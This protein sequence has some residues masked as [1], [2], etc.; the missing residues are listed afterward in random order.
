MA[1]LKVA[2]YS[3]EIPSTTFI[4]QLVK[5][6]GK[7]DMEVLLFG[8]LKKKVSYSGNIRIISYPR[9]GISKR[10]KW[11]IFLIR[12][13]LHSPNKFSYAVR[14]IREKNISWSMKITPILLYQPDVFHL[15]WAKAV[16][17]WLFLKE[18]FGVKLVISLR[19]A[20]INYSPVGSPEVADIYKRSFPQYDI[21]HAVSHDIGR[22]ARWY[23]MPQDRVRVIR[24]GLSIP[25]VET[26]ML[27][28]KGTGNPIKLISIGRPHWIKG[29]GYALEALAEFAKQNSF[30]YKIV[31]GDPSEEILFISHELGIDDKIIYTGKLSQNEILTLLDQSDVMVLPSIAEGIANVAVEAMARGCLVLSSNCTGMPELVQDGITGFLYNN[32][33]SKHLTTVLGKITAMN[34]EQLTMIRK[35][36]LQKILEEYQPDRLGIEMF[37]LYKEV[38]A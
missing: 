17:D 15:Q 22:R 19:G 8:T 9:N 34:P 7:L 33:D 20:H 14:A 27:S 38:C 26:E 4:E 25:P 24:T 16:E 32:Y 29:Y 18:K 36:A 6:V 30:E 35:Q 12:L 2:I 3:G 28:P 21:A 1:K 10:I 31:G 13:L 23:G 37:E 11:C 5:T